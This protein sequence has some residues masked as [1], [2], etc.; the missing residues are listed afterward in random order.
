M[1]K[2]YIFL[3]LIFLLFLPQFI[4]GFAQKTIEI[5]GFSIKGPIEDQV[6]IRQVVETYLQNIQAVNEENLTT[7]LQTLTKDAQSDSSK[8]LSESFDSYDLVI[9]ARTIELVHQDEQLIKLRVRQ[10]IENQ[11]QTPYRNHLATMG[12]SFI[13]ENNQWKIAES[14]VEDTQFDYPKEASK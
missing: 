6:H 14:I 3:G 7:Y 11:N 1:R 2:R 13:V 9:Q 10:V 12:I 4:Q 5:D 8:I